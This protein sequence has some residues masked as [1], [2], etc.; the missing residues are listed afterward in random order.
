MFGVASPRVNG[1]GSFAGFIGSAVDVT[2]QKLARDALEKVSRQLIEAQEKGRR[3]LARELHDDICQRMAM[4]SLKIEKA[5]KGWG[6]GRVPVSEQL[7]QIWKQCSDLTG[8][9]QA[10][11][12]ELHPSILDNLGLATA[13][14]SFCREVSEQ[15]GVTVEFVGKNIPDSLPREVALSLFRVVQEAGHNA[16]KYSGQK[17]FEVRLEGTS[18]E[19]E[20]EVRDEGVGFDAANTKN[21]GGLGLV[22]MAERWNTDSRARANCCTGESHDCGCEVI[23]DS[24]RHQWPGGKRVA[25]GW[26]LG[27]YRLSIDATRKMWAFFHERPLTK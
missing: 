9:V 21:G 24:V 7:E 1:D 18:R 3:R 12:H 20:L 26:M 5:S 14:K 23:F 17:H 25:A 27:P 2:D 4:L 19:L 6:N 15:S 8:D 13:V 10:L 11:S 16:I 22:S